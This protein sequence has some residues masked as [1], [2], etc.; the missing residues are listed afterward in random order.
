[1]VTW[2]LNVCCVDMLLQFNRRL[3]GKTSSEETKSLGEPP[4]FLL[5]FGTMAALVAW[6]SLAQPQTVFAELLWVSRNSKNKASLA[7]L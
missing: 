5:L 3:P 2:L 1:M 7:R 6:R 4:K